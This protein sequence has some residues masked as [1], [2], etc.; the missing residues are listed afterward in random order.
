M[1]ENFINLNLDA[2]TSEIHPQIYRK[3]E[4]EKISN[5]LTN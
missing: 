5:L 3:P 1:R 4:E 2:F